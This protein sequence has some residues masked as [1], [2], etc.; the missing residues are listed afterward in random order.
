[1]IQVLWQSDGRIYPVSQFRNRGSQAFNQRAWLAPAFPHPSSKSRKYRTVHKGCG[2][3]IF[4]FPAVLTVFIHRKNS[5]KSLLFSLFLWLC[6]LFRSGPSQQHSMPIGSPIVATEKPTTTSTTA[7][8][9]HARDGVFSTEFS[10][11][12][13]QQQCKHLN[14]G[15]MNNRSILFVSGLLNSEQIR[16]T[17]FT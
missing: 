10:G 13:L 1:M 3:T 12:G 17:K 2:N 8:S 11:T 15:R 4:P 5:S 6:F 7:S 14:S 9:G 16:C